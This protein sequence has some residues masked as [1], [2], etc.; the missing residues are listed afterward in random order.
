MRLGDVIGA[1]KAGLSGDLICYQ[2]NPQCTFA[3]IE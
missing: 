1:N 3:K 2:I